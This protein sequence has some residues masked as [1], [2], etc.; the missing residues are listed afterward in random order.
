MVSAPDPDPAGPLD[1]RASDAEREAVIDQLRDHAAAGRL[2]TDELAERLE[3]AY[4][5]RTRGDLARVLRELPQPEPDLSAE[6]RA[7]ARKSL[8]ASLGSYVSTTA[9]L[10]GI[11]ALSGSGSFWPG[12]IM[13][14]WGIALVGQAWHAFGPYAGEE[15]HDP[16]RRHRG[17][18]GRRHRR[19]PP[20]PERGR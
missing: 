1:L 20:P 17:H 6:R 3:E 4:G 18:R 11:W 10:V 2:D 9:V 19:L 14:F 13:L 5:A 8:Y 16:R 7:R 12:W 15:E